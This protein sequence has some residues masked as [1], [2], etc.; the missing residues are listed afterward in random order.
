MVLEIKDF[1]SFSFISLKFHFT[2]FLRFVGFCRKIQLYPKGLTY[3]KG[4]HLSLF[5]YSV[6]L[7]T[8]SKVYIDYT[9]RI[10][11]QLHAKHITFKAD[12]CF[13]DST[14][15]WG[16]TKFV[17]LSHLNDPVNGC[18]VKDICVVEAEVNVW[19]CQSSTADIVK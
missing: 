12:R 5:L 17:S 13:I 10:L 1:I 4:S 19:G 11:D 9:I 6:D 16:W 3:P 8:G 15:G 18:L 2:K 14:N 7:T